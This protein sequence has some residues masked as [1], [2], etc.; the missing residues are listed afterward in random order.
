MDHDS[1]RDGGRRVQ[2]LQARRLLAEHIM[3]GDPLDGW[4]ADQIVAAG[5]ASMADM[6][7]VL[8]IDGPAAEYIGDTW[9]AEADEDG[10]PRLVWSGRRS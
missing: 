3:T 5:L 6:A 10:Q 1:V 9:T 4:V 2:L 7:A 8:D